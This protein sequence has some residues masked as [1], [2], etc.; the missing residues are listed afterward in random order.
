MLSS[1][2][3][4]SWWCLR[5]ITQLIRACLVEPDFVIC[6][7]AEVLHLMFRSFCLLESIQSFMEI[8][9]SISI[10]AGNRFEANSALF[11][12]VIYVSI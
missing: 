7:L 4:N 11:F 12:G 1:Y 2:H 3:L 10:A 9:V 8:F 5:E 6:M